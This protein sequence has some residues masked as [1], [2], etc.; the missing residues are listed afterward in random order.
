MPRVAEYGVSVDIVKRL[1]RELVNDLASVTGTSRDHFSIQVNSDTFL[2]DV[3]EVQPDVFVEFGLFERDS[4]V[5]DK[6]ARIVTTHVQQAGI[7][8]V[9]FYLNHFSRRRYF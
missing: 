6:M 8:S 7:A 3:A 4:T 9:E 1:S 5:E 2:F